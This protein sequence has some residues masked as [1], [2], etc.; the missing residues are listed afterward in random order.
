MC[1]KPEELE[2]KPRKSNMKPQGRRWGQ[3][4]TCDFKLEKRPERG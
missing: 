4:V 1:F 2:K 3:K